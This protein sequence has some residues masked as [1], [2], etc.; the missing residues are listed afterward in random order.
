MSE[1]RD[2]EAALRASLAEN[3]RHAPRGDVV[4]AEVLATVARPAPAPVHPVRRW[5]S[6]T[7]PLIAAGSVAAVAAALVGVGA[8]HHSATHHAPPA[9][10][11]V[12]PPS[13]S[14]APVTPGPSP[15]AITGSTIAKNVGLTHF[16]VSDLTF[17]GAD[18][19][20]AIGLADC[21]SGSPGACPAMVRT[22]DGGLNW[23][24]MKPPPTVVPGSG[25]CG[26]LSQ[27]AQYIRF[28]TQQIGYAY[29]LNAFFM[30]KNG[31]ASWT[32][33]VAGVA[34]LETLDNNVIRVLVEP[35]CGTCAPVRAQVAPI[36]STTW[37]DVALPGPV[38]TLG[39]VTLSRS[40]HDAYLEEYGD[41]T[42]PSGHPQGVLLVSHNDGLTW[43][44]KGEPCSAVAGGTLVTV[45]ITT[46]P[47]GSVSLLC[48]S[49]NQGAGPEYISTS[50]DQGQT[51]TPAAASAGQSID[52]IGAA[53]ARVLVA[54]AGGLSRSV[55]GGASW[56]QVL[57]P[58]TQ[59]SGFT[60]LG[61]ESATTGR[62]V[63]GDASTVWTTHD[64]GQT[65]T[66]ITFG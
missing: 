61:F 64:A 21:L 33:E 16:R 49:M 39:S 15:T 7:L 59:T 26:K 29:G 46:A 28:A 9:S 31:G 23:H 3:A 35:W 25:G 55:D 60:F 66:S 58:P 19:G 8:A 37:T 47:D 17:V 41:G 34:A 13:P 40:G 50:I 1:I 5:G 38:G 12:P 6:W 54:S 14:S 43:A 57:S 20:W 36:G 45:S 52:M 32:S 48:G 22:T 27:C 62:W 4:A 56:N 10:H 18:N 51:F 63:S 44:N 2:V 53:S 30:T 11:A 65:W 42:L 24:S